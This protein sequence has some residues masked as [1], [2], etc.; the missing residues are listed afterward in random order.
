MHTSPHSARIETGVSSVLFEHPRRSSLR[1]LLL[2]GTGKQ[3]P[4]LVLISRQLVSPH[5]GRDSHLSL[6]RPV[7]H[8]IGYQPRLRT[9]ILSCQRQ[10]N[11]SDPGAQI[12]DDRERRCAVWYS[13]R[14]P[15]GWYPTETLVKSPIALR[16]LNHA[17]RAHA[18]FPQIVSRLNPSRSLHKPAYTAT[19]RRTS[20][21][22]R[23]W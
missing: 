4:T 22:S 21:S 19:R 18:M 1:A 6:G 15:A 16:L 9:S 12:L 17:G 10:L 2:P 23:I 5:V 14:D 20:V 7:L 13:R 8:P 3:S 11:S